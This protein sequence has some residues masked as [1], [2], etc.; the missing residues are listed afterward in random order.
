[1]S[2]LVKKDIKWVW[3][4]AQQQVF[5]NI[6]KKFLEDIIIQF[7]DF[8]R[9]FYI[10]T[11]ASTTHVGAELHQIN[12]EGRHKSLGFSSQILNSAER[13]YNTTELELLAI[14]FT[15]KKFQH[16]LLGHQVKVLTDHHALTFLNT[17]QL[18]NSRLVR[19]STFL[20]EY[21]LEIVHVLGRE[22][23]R[24]DTLTR[25]PQYPTEEPQASTRNIIINKLALL[26]YSPE[27]KK[28]FKDLPA[29]QQTDEH[30][31]KLKLRMNFWKEHN[32]VVYNQLLF[33]KSNM[34]EYQIIVPRELI[35]PLVI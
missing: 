26:D 9:E 25:Y 34:E 31:Q 13:N 35:K 4:T 14:V 5:E 20:Q 30:I 27:L 10:N 18:L 32:L 2:A 17:C 29:L 8:T 24:A 21:Q 11:D 6:K 19:W 23:I 33:R 28:Q 1:M 7:P 3:G 22:N 15:C 12:E 16:Y